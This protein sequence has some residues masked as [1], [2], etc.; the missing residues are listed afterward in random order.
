M[1]TK[2][3]ILA[4]AVSASLLTMIRPSFSQTW[5]Q[6][7]AP[8]TNWTSIAC[9]ADGR[10]IVAVAGRFEGF[11]TSYGVGQIYIS[12][13]SGT[14]WRLTSAPVTNWASVA[15][16][17]DGTRLVAAVGPCCELGP[18]YASADSGVTWAQTSAP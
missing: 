13:D 17:A 16:S 14:T 9:S 12:D 7:S 4:M 6:T 18:I 3:R 8:V 5:T 2:L 1:T 11:Q 10:N 15:S